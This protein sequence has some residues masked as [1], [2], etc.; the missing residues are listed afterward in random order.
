MHNKLTNFS[1]SIRRKKDAKVAKIKGSCSLLI[2][3]MFWREKNGTVLIVVLLNINI[4]MAAN[5]MITK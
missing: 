4:E 2:K 5:L 3:W 1:L